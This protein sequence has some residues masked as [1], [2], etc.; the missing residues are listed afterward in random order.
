MKKLVAIVL[1]VCLL[2]AGAVGFLG[3]KNH[4]HEESS[5]AEYSVPEISTLDYDAIYALHDPSEVVLRIDGKDVTWGEYFYW[6]FVNG[7]QV[8]DQMSM[9]AMYGLPMSWTDPIDESG[10]SY[11]SYVSDG[12]VDTMAVRQSILG[13]TEQAGY[14]MDDEAQAQ[15]AEQKKQDMT[16]LCGEGATEADFEQALA[17]I[18]MTP[19]MYDEMMKVAVL[20]QGGFKLLYGKDGENVSD[21]DAQSVLDEYGFLNANHILLLTTDQQTGELLSEEETAARKAQAEGFTAELRA[22]E[23]KDAL[24]ARFRELKESFDEDGGKV[25]NPDGYVFTPGQMVPEF[26]NG[27]LALEDYEVSEPVKSS[28]G[29]H[30]ILRLPVTVDTVL[31]MSSEGTPMTARSI[32]ANNDYGAKLDAY[33]ESMD[34]EYVG[35]FAAPDLSAYLG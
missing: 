10:M 34:I 31:T 18:Y 3:G 16:S 33:L 6:I 1:A 15:L 2:F 11:L 22:I 23:D 29:Y 24:L 7:R 17:E 13:F 5:A 27:V 28:Y 30:V 12:V 14:V 19:E 20:Y 25:S 32:Y 21:A 4:V 35:G 26:E 8:E 9:M